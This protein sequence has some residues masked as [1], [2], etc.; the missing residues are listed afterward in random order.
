M[1]K[2]SYA[3]GMNIA[4]NLMSSGFKEIDLDSFTKALSD[5]KN[6]VPTSISVNEAN[7]LLQDYFTKIQDEMLNKNL[8]EGKAFLAENKKRP[9]VKTLP[10]G[11]QYEVLEEG[12]GKTPKSTDKVSCHY[13]GTL[14]N[15]TVFDSQSS[16]QRLGRG[17]SIDERRF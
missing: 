3:L 5:M 17:S 4:S 2:L 7:Q 8:E 15:G 12:D 9:E 10:S 14:L 16:N 6:N 13:H 11:L 1:D